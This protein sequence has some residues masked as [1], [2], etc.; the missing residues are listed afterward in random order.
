MGYAFWDNW[1]VWKALSENVPVL[2]ASPFLV[3]VHQNHGYVTT[4]RS[5]GS[6][7]DEIA[8][9]NFELVSGWKRL[10][11][12]GYCTFRL[13]RRGR[14]YNSPFRYNHYARAAERF[15]RFDVWNPIWFFIL[16]IT[17]PLRAMVGLRAGSVRRS[18]R[19]V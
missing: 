12:A 5:K 7:L 4:E 14:I 10:R 19:K 18:R 1:V 16:E 11:H 6:V 2:D 15:L 8:M 9:R 17:R 13:S 3:P